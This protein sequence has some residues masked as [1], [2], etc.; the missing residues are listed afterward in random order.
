MCNSAARA[1][2]RYGLICGWV[3][4]FGFLDMPAPQSHKA[5]LKCG[6]PT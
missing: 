1:L 6:W 5:P 4:A 3:A 2:D